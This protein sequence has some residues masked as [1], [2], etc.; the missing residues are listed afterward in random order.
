MSTVVVSENG[1]IDY[2]G[3]QDNFQ[4]GTE[5][6]LCHCVYMSKLIELYT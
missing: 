4:G 2:K 3:I 1:K 6:I 5:I